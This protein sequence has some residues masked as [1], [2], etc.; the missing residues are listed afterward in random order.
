MS[1]KRPS[2]VTP[3][4][5]FFSWIAAL[6]ALLAASAL[7]EETAPATAAKRMGYSSLFFIGVNPSDARN[8][9]IAITNDFVRESGVTP[10]GDPIIYEN[11]TEIGGLLDRNQLSVVCMATSEYWLLRPRIAFDLF[12]TNIKNGTTDQV[13]V[14]LAREDGP[15]RTLADLRGKRLGELT[16]SDM[17]LA[18]VWLDV[19]LARQHLPP[20]AKLVANIARSNKPAK[21]VLPVF[22]KQLDACLVTRASY[23]LMV[24][25][26]PQVG[27]QLRIVTTSPSYITV[28]YG[29]R[30]DT[31][32]IPKAKVIRTMLDLHK[33]INGRQTLSLFQIE[34]IVEIPATALDSTLALLDEHARLCPEASAELIATLRG[35][36]QSSLSTR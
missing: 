22:F 29:F 7:A 19:E 21:V 28:F 8:A 11:V 6:L 30:P 1:M 2:P 14:V 34:K 10:D 24:E 12:L 3:F 16:N 32:A 35:Q 27:R 5:R 18:D 26:N 23:N 25:L 17:N 13:Y 33:S 31:P 15:I 4:L 20:T 36:E 9:L